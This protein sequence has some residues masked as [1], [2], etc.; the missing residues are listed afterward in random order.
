MTD[1]PTLHLVR[2]GTGFGILMW[3]VWFNY[4]S[5]C[6]SFDSL[7]GQSDGF[8]GSCCSCVVVHELHRE[9]DDVCMQGTFVAIDRCK[10]RKLGG[11]DVTDRSKSDLGWPPKASVTSTSMY[12]YM[13]G[14]RCHNRSRAA[15]EARSIRGKS[16]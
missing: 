5:D 7:A 6:I 2:S 12:K 11:R 4:D 16:M 10:A 9:S 15:S 13:T 1:N 8:A 3:Y 14:L